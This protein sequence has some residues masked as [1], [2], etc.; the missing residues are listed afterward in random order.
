MRKGVSGS[1]K[2]VDESEFVA[3]LKACKPVEG[4]AA[5]TDEDLQVLQYM[6]VKLA[7]KVMTEFV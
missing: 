4:E 7:P 6:C 5:L 1:H 2:R 3:F